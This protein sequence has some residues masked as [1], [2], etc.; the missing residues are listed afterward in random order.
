MGSEYASS[1]HA[2]VAGLAP[3]SAPML[4]R[5]TAEMVISE[6]TTSMPRPSATTGAHRV[7]VSPPGSLTASV[8]MHQTLEP[9]LT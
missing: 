6:V 8:V 1:T 9:Q 5:A 7:R 4:G 2:V 3:R